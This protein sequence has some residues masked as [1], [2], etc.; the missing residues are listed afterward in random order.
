MF[1]PILVISGPCDVY[2][3]ISDSI[4]SNHERAAQHVLVSSA[5]F[6]RG[7]LNGREFE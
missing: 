1:V 3:G 5:A 6:V 2:V 4:I 7:M